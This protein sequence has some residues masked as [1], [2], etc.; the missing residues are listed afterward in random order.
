M[1]ALKTW[2]LA[3]GLLTLLGI[4]SASAITFDTNTKIA[5]TETNY[6]GQ[7][8]VVTNCTVTIEGTHSF[9]N[10]LILNGGVVTHTATN[11]GT[12]T[13]VLSITN[14]QQILSDT[15]PP[16]LNNSSVISNTV[17]VKDI[18]G[19]NVYTNGIDYSYTNGQIFRLTNSAIADGDSILVSY[20]FTVQTTS[21]LW[22]DI[23]NNLEIEA[24]GAINAAGKGNSPGT[25]SGAGRT[26][27]I[28][29]YNI[30]SGGGHGG[31]GGT[32]SS[33]VWGGGSYGSITSPTTFGSGGGAGMGTGGAGGGVIHLTVGNIVRV[34]GM[35]TANGDRATNSRSGGGSGGSIYISTTSLSGNGVISANG[36]SGELSLGGGGGGG[37]IAIT[38]TTNDFN[39]DIVARGGA[40]WV[41]GGAGTVYLKPNGGFAK[42]TVDNRGGTGTN[43]YVPNTGAGAVYDLVVK[44][45][46][47]ASI[48]SL[49]VRTLLVTSNSWIVPDI[50]L[51][52]SILTCGD[53]IIDG[54][55]GINLDRKGYGSGQGSGA[56]V[57]SSIGSG[58]GGY[59]GQGGYGAGTTTGGNAYDNISNP[60]NVG[61]GGGSVSGVGGI[62]AGA[63]SFTVTNT[64][65][66]AGKI[67]ANGGDATG[68]YG[69][70]GSAGGI[71]V[72]VGLL[73]GDGTITAEGGA[74][75]MPTGGGGG[76]GRIAISYGTNLFTG[77]YSAVGGYGYVFGGAGT[78]YLKK[79]S[80]PTATL[81]TDNGGFA[82]AYTPIVSS[83]LY[84][85]IV[86][87]GAVFSNGYGGYSMNSLYVGSN[88]W[89]LPGA[90]LT[91]TSNATVE[92]GA[93][94]YADGKGA[95]AGGGS[96]YGL[97]TSSIGCGGGYGG[98][99][100]GSAAYTYGGTSYG[101]MTTPTDT[102]SGGG[103]GSGG[104]PYNLGGAGGGAAR[105]TVTRTLTIN[106]TITANG[107]TGP[108]SNSGG[109]SG[110]SIYLTVGTLSG[111]GTI[112]ANGGDAE[113]LL[114]GGG[115]GGRIAVYYNT[116]NFVGAMMARGGSGKVYGGAGTI[117]LKPANGL[118]QVLANNGGNRGANTPYTAQSPYD[119]SV[120]GGASVTNST[121]VTLNSLI[122][123]SNSSFVPYSTSS[124][125]T[126]NGN[127]TVDAGGT[128]S[129]D[130]IISSSTGNGFSLSS[131]GGGGAHGGYGG[132]SS[133]NAQ[134]GTGHDSLSAPVSVGGAGGSG[135]NYSQGGYG[136]GVV[137][138]NINGTLTVNGELSADG[139]SP[140]AGSQ[141]GGGA[142][143][144]VKLVLGKLAGNGVISAVGGNGD[145]SI[146]GG[147]G[148]G[149]I[150]INYGTNIFAGAIKASGGSG[151]NAGGA[152][153]IYL[154][155][156]SNS[157]ARVTMD[158]G[159]LSGALTVLPFLSD[160]DLT[161]TGGAKATN[162]YGSLTINNLFI[163]SNSFYIPSYNYAGLTVNTN[164]IIEASGGISMDGKGTASTGNGSS[165]GS[166]GSGGGHGGMG[167]ASLTV[168]GGQTYDSIS[169][170]TLSGSSGGV[171][172]TG[173]ISAPGGG[174]ISLTV[175]GTLTLNGAL[176]VNGIAGLSS[177]GGGGS[178]GS[179]YLF[180]GTLA[181]SGNISANGGAGRNPVGGGG[182]GGRI[183]VWY[184]T[185]NFVGPITAYGGTGTNAGG[186][187]TVYMR[188]RNSN[189]GTVLIEN[190]GIRGANTV[191][192]GTLENISV[193]SGASAAFSSTLT[194]VGQLTVKSNGV[195][196]STATNAAGVNLNVTSNLVVE[197]G[198]SI[199]L[200]GRGNSGGSGTGAGSYTP[201]SNYG[202]I[203]G[204]G[205]HGG[206]GGNAGTN[207]L[208]GIYH[209]N[210]SSPTSF[211]G[212]GG[213]AGFTGGSGGGSLQL[214]ITSGNLIVDGAI[215]ANGLMGSTNN[216]GGGAGGSILITMNNGRLSGTGTIA[217]NGGAGEMPWGGGGGGGRIAIYYKTNSFAGAMTAFG[218]A[219]S[220][221]G[222]AGTIYLKSLFSSPEVLIANAGT[223]GAT[224]PLLSAG[225]YSIS[226][227]GGGVAYL[228]TSVQ[229]FNNFVIASN[230]W[231]TYSNSGSTEYT[232][233]SN[234]V[235]QK[236]GAIALAGMGSN[237]GSGSGVGGSS[238][239]G[240]GGSGHGGYGGQGAAA[241]GGTSY[242]S[243]TQPSTV[244]SGSPSGPS[245]S[246]AGGASLHLM[247]TKTLQLDGEINV[248]GSSAIAANG[249]GA[250]GGSVWLSAG[251][252]TGTGKITANGGAGKNA[253]GGG[254]GGR[255]A[256]IYSTNTFTGTITAC[257]GSGLVS[258]GAG[259]IYMRAAPNTVGTLVVDNGGL[260]GTNTPLA[261]TEATQLT[262]ANGANLVSPAT[263]TLTS[264][265]IANGG[266][267][268]PTNSS[269][270][271][272]LTILQNATV[273]GLLAMDRKGST[274]GPGVG[275]F[276]TSGS[277]GGYG[278]AGGASSS[279]LG[280]GV[281]G[282][283]QTP[284]NSGS[285]G[286]IPLSPATGTYSPGG[287]V[288]RMKVGRT[289]T[290]DGTISSSGSDGLT[291]DYGGGSGGS[292]WITTSNL[293][294]IG[295][296]S[297]N[298]GAGEPSNAGGGGGG[299]VAI[300]A[301]ANSFLGSAVAL[302]GAG[303]AQ[304]DAGTVYFGTNFSG[305]IVVSQSLTG[306]TASAFSIIDLT[307][308]SPLDASTL[309]GNFTL[310]APTGT[311]S[312]QTVTL[313]SNSV[314][315]LNFGVQTNVGLYT[316]NSGQL[317]KDIYGL[318]APASYAGAITIVPATISG[319]VTDTN[320]VP[321]SGVSLQPSG[322]LA[323]LITDT[324]GFY[325]LSVAPTWSGTI[326]PTDTNST[327]LP[328]LR[329][330]N[331]VAGNLTNQNFVMVPPD[332]M[333][334]SSSAQGTNLS[335]GIF[336]ASQ[337][338]YQVYSSTNLINW[339]PYGSPIIGSNSAISVTIPMD[340]RTNL[341]FEIRAN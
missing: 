55:S 47:T 338:S 103:N 305:P 272:D 38:Y 276:G 65:F 79:N 6:D 119:V 63:I 289:L 12:L 243:I 336:G 3:V 267:L 122:V 53:A 282:S 228:L 87:G 275:Q 97:S 218:G 202:T 16:Y 312:P 156:N 62:G 314:V 134:G 35:I 82:G 28:Y 204:G 154:K 323:E 190:N 136:G 249:G 113:S 306:A 222:G 330:F 118:G 157:F 198:G 251:I 2:S 221:H 96:G 196:T 139:G 236:G 274:S 83:G 241:G 328:A 240:A 215:T 7:D 212:G 302:G 207:G 142:G 181:G 203:G 303:W 37:R 227:S 254:G 304:G 124:A 73:A 57:S 21:S 172:V 81:L 269:S 316:V 250:S 115:G 320:N 313:L 161:I 260:I 71:L 287:G 186:A 164:A 98:T 326:T 48:L 242:G 300:D 280:G 214:T 66:L 60:L 213:G 239:S 34:D 137:T 78:I 133:F 160:F 68:P 247:T 229:T 270:T 149:R 165:S 278:G 171:G 183:A 167:G 112:S 252:F 296:I 325:L 178:G 319:W 268:I 292:I 194:Y 335:L 266:A 20:D 237:G 261:T 238:S 175:N 211:G 219:G 317:V 257:G 245:P 273:S 75:D 143:G 225:T 264:L 327:Y 295:I 130:G 255:I 199:T 15:N 177:S 206:R 248:E 244:G 89:V 256:I 126:I 9:G 169:T 318:N 173:G 110:G 333:T 176:S 146:G 200:D 84:D 195:V 217:V 150:A 111:T 77:T 253:G 17:V 135:T 141:A 107:L 189:T 341:F 23:T 40:G 128:I 125:T 286:G 80:S 293:N 288:L 197:A 5:V 188:Q 234:A 231:L 86:T 69:G 74:G 102:G 339:L 191:L 85:V 32:G 67:T 24:G 11:T 44:G 36:G 104:T 49:Q 43:T 46:A 235:I 310:E 94:I 148:G 105:M 324:N 72:N 106:G 166:N 19:T 39:G 99:G 279:A 22:L 158:N 230:A 226:I 192:T 31:Y 332:I 265:N 131:S 321:I 121:A 59:G 233:F 340:A 50:S 92:A 76:G 322:G 220:N 290:V 93:V 159:G 209:D 120:S 246:V 54:T 337:V 216:C 271:L 298:G 140:A 331:N 285:G 42:L 301:M 14:E 58:G 100:G 284:T 334:L 147:G 168:A 299:R 56:G 153:T 123:S 179:V 132:M 291:D 174:V 259:T 4:S 29:P 151:G 205:G 184:N 283:L 144:T 294:G 13:Y 91:I 64:L 297:A 116:N 210:I 277:G 309:A 170:P 281:Y 315:R 308:G 127:V 307:F 329:S 61:S 223:K 162:S 114:G 187:G 232:I 263:V 201:T 224:T 311:L 163:G 101:S 45:K 26:V 117:F 30:G 88:A 95:A 90:S 108:G 52:R 10:L 155:A 33:N 41:Y 27:S 258:G 262:V 152:G 51:N 180:L 145:G 109:G 193:G 138:L 18:T 70:G 185:N 25:G 1:K 182:G 208:G 8:I 129:L